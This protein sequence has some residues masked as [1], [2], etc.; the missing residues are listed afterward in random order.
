MV[1]FE[2][3]CLITFFTQMHWN[4]F[5]TFCTYNIVIIQSFAIFLHYPFVSSFCGG[6]LLFYLFFVALSGNGTASLACYVES[7]QWTCTTCVIPNGMQPTSYVRW[8]ARNSINPLLWLSLQNCR[9][10]RWN[11]QDLT[12]TRDTVA[13]REVSPLTHTSFVGLA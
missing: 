3:R 5:G 9:K 1:C 11:C 6:G 7:I 2:K 13:D 4:I 12:T 10:R 8:P